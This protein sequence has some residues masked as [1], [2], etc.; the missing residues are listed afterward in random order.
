MGSPLPVVPASPQGRLEPN[1]Y[2]LPLPSAPPAH[3]AENEKYMQ[4]QGRWKQRTLIYFLSL[5]MFSPLG[6][7]V[8]HG[9]KPPMATRVVR[10]RVSGT[11]RNLPRV[12]SLGDEEWLP[13]YSGRLGWSGLC[14]QRRFCLFINKLHSVSLS[15]FIDGSLFIACG[16]ISGFL[17]LL[18]CLM[19]PWLY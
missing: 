1:L 15:S 19:T 9:A 12:E 13:L 8:G 4:V 7:E 18:Q 14:W 10:S 17:V 16:Y 3:C 11:R 5:P 6:I 2:C